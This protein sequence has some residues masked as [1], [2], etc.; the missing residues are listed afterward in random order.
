MHFLSTLPSGNV[1]SDARQGKLLFYVSGESIDSSAP[2]T[3]TLTASRPHH[4]PTPSHFQLALP[5]SLR[6]LKS[7]RRGSD[8]DRQW[9]ASMG[10][11]SAL[12]GG[13]FTRSFP[14]PIRSPLCSSQWG[15]A[16]RG[17]EQGGVGGSWFG[18]SRAKQGASRPT[19]SRRRGDEESP[20]PLPPSKVRDAPPGGTRTPLPGGKEVGAA[21]P[22]HPLRLGHPGGAGPGRAGLEKAVSSSKGTEVAILSL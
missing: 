11:S 12:P 22:R 4:S 7:L 2:R 6:F 15:L 18:W 1:S 8:F 14:C 16:A 5:P 19:S 9:S 3:D 21:Q 10:F 20:L 13:V 17:L